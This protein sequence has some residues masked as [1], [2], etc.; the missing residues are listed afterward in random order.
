[1]NIWTQRS[2]ELANQYDYLDQL[3]KVY[4]LSP[5][6]KRELS[7]EVIKK[8][9]VFYNT[10][11]S[12]ALINLLLDQV[13]GKNGEQHPFP[14]KY[15][16]V[17]YFK[18]DRTAIERNPKT[19]DRIAGYLYDMGLTEILDKTSAPK[20][21]N[22]QMGYLFKSYIDKGTLGIKVLKN[23]IEFINTSEDAVFNCSDKQ[24]ENFAK[25]YLGYTRDKG[26]DFIARVNN[27]YVIGET[28]F[29]TDFGGS[30]NSDLNDAF[31][32]LN[33]ELKPTEFNVKKII[34]LDGVAYIKS[35][36]KDKMFKR[37]TSCTDDTVILSAVLLREFLGSI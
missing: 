25:K 31:Y 22:R 7:T 17:S 32:T 5:N 34:I 23:E 13:Q 28:K 2:I 24:G 14:I 6:E 4:S 33:S 20:E 11:N 12:K 3:F 16:Y 35:K 26:L 15:S 29:L 8:I 30:Q 36:T 21:T 1:M 37:I 10:K 9:H 27:I 19:V 18:H